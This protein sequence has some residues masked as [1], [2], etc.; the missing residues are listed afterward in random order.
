[1]SAH[2]RV[3]AV[4]AGLCLAGLAATAALRADPYTDGP[5]TPGEDPTPAESHPVDCEEIA[6]RVARDVREH[7]E[8]QGRAAPS[9]SPAYRGDTTFTVTLVP[10]ECADELEAR[11]LSS[12]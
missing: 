12:P 8:A 3:V 11:G 10:E 7:D 6:D 5:G 2:R 9:V 1:M 4:W